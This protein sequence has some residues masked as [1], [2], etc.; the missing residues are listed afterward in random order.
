VEHVGPQLS[1][2]V[3]VGSLKQLA[4][5]FSEHSALVQSVSV[6]KDLREGVRA[7]ED[8]K[9]RLDALVFEGS[10]LNLVSGH[11]HHHVVEVVFGHLLHIC[12]KQFVFLALRSRFRILEQ[13]T[14]LMTVEGRAHLQNLGKTV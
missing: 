7:D 3:L 12:R 5:A 9:D 13:S 14:S 11:E 4:R 8:L 6:L 10:F 1:Q 2:S